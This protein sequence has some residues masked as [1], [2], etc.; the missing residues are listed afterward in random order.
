MFTQ[1]PPATVSLNSSVPFDSSQSEIPST[2]F[3]DNRTIY[4]TTLANLIYQ[5]SSRLSFSVGGGF[6]DNIRSSSALYG[7]L[8]ETG[9]ADAQYRVSRQTTVGGDYSYSHY[10]YTGS[11]GG[12]NIHTA[13]LTVSTRF[14]RWTELSLFGG[15]A[16]VSSSFQQTVPI[17]PAILAILCPPNVVAVCPL[18]ASTVIN[19][20][21]F[22][23]PDFGIRLSRSFQRGVAYL[24]AGETITPGNGLFLTSR[25]ASASV[26]YGYS[27][28]RKWNMSIGAT[29]VRSL[30]FG[31]VQGGYGDLSGSYSVS[32]QLTGKL[33]FVSS[34]NAT[35]YES[36]SFSAYNR[37]IYSA[38]IGLGYSSRDIPVRFF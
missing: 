6:F 17:D 24:S 37:L 31:N 38:S 28:L 2:D 30:S 33:S 27:G 20:S 1:F 13:A 32:R 11:I 25:T 10:S 26:G 4:T 12:A 18:T 8:G 15:A 34:F 14:D 19:R 16:R 35:K 36:S 23:G 22:W 29:Y 3:Y 21:V 7:A 5:A 9:S